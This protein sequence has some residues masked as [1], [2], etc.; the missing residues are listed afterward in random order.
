MPDDIIIEEKIDDIE[1]KDNPNS[2]DLPVSQVTLDNPEIFFPKDEQ[3]P[4]LIG[5]LAYLQNKIL[6]PP[7]A[8]NDNIEGRIIVQFLVDKKGNVHHAKII[9]GLR[10]DVNKEAIKAIS[11]CRFT[12]AK[13]NGK[14]I[15]SESVIYIRFEIED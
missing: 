7:K 5:G 8:I 10:E 13:L 2:L 15:A 4:K 6:Y 11:K 9:K 3:R 12:P 1:M 14:P